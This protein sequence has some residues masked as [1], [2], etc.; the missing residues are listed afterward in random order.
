LIGFD[1]N[2]IAVFPSISSATVE[3]AVN[4]ASNMQKNEIVVRPVSLYILMSSPNVKYET[5]IVTTK[6]A[7]AKK[8]ITKKA[9]WRIA[10]LAV[11][12]A[13]V[14]DFMVVVSG[15]PNESDEEKK[16]ISEIGCWIVRETSVSGHYSANGDQIINDESRIPLKGHRQAARNRIRFEFP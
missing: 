3:L 14:S 11:A 13:I 16:R 12:K 7:P 2:V 6:S 10:S 15:F 5:K 9:G 1:S 8:A 4:N